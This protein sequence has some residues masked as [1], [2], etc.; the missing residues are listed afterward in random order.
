MNTGILMPPPS[1]A[2]LHTKKE[3][4]T[5]A[6][7][8]PSTNKRVDRAVLHHVDSNWKPK[9]WK[10]NITMIDLEWERVRV[11][12]DLD[13]NHDPFE[14]AAASYW[15]IEKPTGLYDVMRDF[16]RNAV[17]AIY[18]LRGRITIEAIAGDVTTV[19]EQ[20][21]WGLVGHRSQGKSVEDTDGMSLDKLEITTRNEYPSAYDCVHLSNIPDYIGGTIPIV[22]YALPIVFREPGSYVTFNCLR[23]TP[24]FGSHAHYNNEYAAG[25]SKPTDLEKTFQ[26]RLGK[27]D[28]DYLADYTSWYHSETPIRHLQELMPRTQLETWLY[29]FFLKTAIPY[30]RNPH[31]F[32]LI[33]SP[34]N[35]T[36]VF[37][38]CE[39]LHE[40]GYPAHWL[41]GVLSA[42]MSGSIT[43]TARPPRS[44]PLTLK[45]VKTI[46]PERT[47][48]TRQFAAE[49]ST[50]ATIWSTFSSFP[51]FSSQIPPIETI[52]QY[53]V[54][55]DD[56]YPHPSNVVP[57]FVLVFMDMTKIA[58]PGTLHTWLLD[59][60]LARR[61][62][63]AEQG[64]RGAMHVLTTWQYDCDERTAQ[65]WLAKDVMGKMKQGM[66]AV[67]IWRSDVYM[68]WTPHRV[69]GED[70]EDTGKFWIAD[71]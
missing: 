28:F 55:F 3:Y 51:I 70:V 43:T 29:R 44:E 14:F 62:K 19:L 12:D 71:A 60:E 20:I 13:V 35:L 34:L 32:A 42:I 40:A 8:R 54:R 49:M 57:T 56:D 18:S 6:T 2:R 48:S 67:Q 66:W 41:S 65:F 31:N 69:V 11:D 27:H 30:P 23:N 58:D 52:R 37:R 25:L 1:L 64:R 68:P 59:D 36:A 33:Y 21:R 53:R 47:Q 15:T 46:M 5:Y 16:F 7:Y 10:P 26:A 9:N 39:L 61:D 17:A 38:V 22:L 50:L 4:D 63:M 45:E 24:R